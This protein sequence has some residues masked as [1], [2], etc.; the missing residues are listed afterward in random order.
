MQIWVKKH[1][2]SNFLKA[3][4]WIHIQICFLGSWINLLVT[5]TYMYK[6][7]NGYPYEH[8]FFSWI[9]IHKHIAHLFVNN[10]V[11]DSKIRTSQLN[12]S[13]DICE[14][15]FPVSDCV[16]IMGTQKN[17]RKRARTSTSCEI[18]DKIK[19]IYSMCTSRQQSQHWEYINEYLSCNFLVVIE[20]VHARCYF[21]F[22]QLLIFTFRVLVDQERRIFRR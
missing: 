9:T 19:P 3:W 15:I 4:I 8:E 5:I 7:I 18:A 17:R 6:L 2:F 16:T 21:Q 12:S 1:A 13:N 22:Q 10:N 14:V 11:Y 20:V